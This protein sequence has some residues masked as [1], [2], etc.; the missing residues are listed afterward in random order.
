M[1]RSTRRDFSLHPVGVE[2]W[3]GFVFVHL[4]P[5][6]P[7]PFADGV[8]QAAANLGNYAMGELVTGRR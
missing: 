2:E 6:A 8:A 4:T 5:G 1:S 7:S 3:A